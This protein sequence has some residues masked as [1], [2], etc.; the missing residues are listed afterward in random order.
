MQLYANPD[1]PDH[2]ENNAAFLKIVKKFPHLHLH[3][4]SPE[5]APWHWQAIISGNG[6]YRQTLN[7]WPHLMKGQRDG[8]K[9]V[10]GSSAII[11]IIEGAFEDSIYQRDSI[12]PDLDLIEE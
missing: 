2:A 8:Y 11:G 4:P 9:S 3:Q 12:E 6:G 10:H 1:R 5:K 7:F